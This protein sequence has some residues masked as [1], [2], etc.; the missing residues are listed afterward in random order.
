MSRSKIKKVAVVIPCYNEAASIA[1]V[2]GKLPRKKLQKELCELSVFVVDNN[3]SDNTAQ[4]A[5]K[6][7]ATVIYEPRKGKGYALRAAFANLPG[8]IDYVAML[9]GDDTYSSRELLRM[10]EPLRS[11]FCDVVVGSRLGGHIQASAM[12]PLNRLG[13][14][15][16][17]NAVRVVYR[18]NVTDVLTGYFAWR[19]EALDALHPH[20]KSEGF[21]IEMEM[22]TKMARLKQ[23]L[24]SVPISYHP[25][26]GK[27]NLYPLRDGARILRMF[28]K[29]L[30]WRARNESSSPSRRIVFVSDS[31]Y[32]YMMGGKEKRLHEISK[33]LANMGYD[34]H[35]Y[36]MHWWKSPSKSHIEDGVTFHALCRYYDMYY[37]DR[38]AIKEGI[39]FGLA[40]FKLIGVK[41]DVLDVDHMPFFP[42]LTSWMIC[43]LRGR[44][45][46]GTWHEALSLQD[47]TQYMGQSGIVAALIERISIHLPHT[48]TAASAQT[49]ELLASVHGRVE[50][51]GLVASGIDIDLMKSIKPANIRCDV[52][53]VGRLVKDKNVDVL[54]DAIGVMFK[55]DPQVSCS[56]IG[57]GIE[58]PRLVRQVAK[59]GLQKNI[60]FIESVADAA[61]VYA[62]MKA[63]KVFCSASTREGFGIVSLEALSC[64]TPVV[65]IDTAA[66][67]ARHL[68]QDGQNGSI[69]SLSPAALASSMANW[70]KQVQ[71]PNIADQ[72][73]EYDWNHLAQKQAEVYS[74]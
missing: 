20:L 1:Q 19:K 53:Y 44:K 2:I 16:F 74:L 72:V 21:A 42:I 55:Q 48:I 29:N 59:L 31:V 25:R 17:T 35:I 5:K 23:R 26:L 8:D 57:K 69:V 46:Y 68:I 24:T 45:F 52:L 49:K 61:D 36:T 43:K 58:K 40:C 15:F 37:G 63:A 11:N 27:S 3:S 12:A 7:G 33:R 22:V 64:G 50:R 18:A 56:I 14:W 4:C 39:M 38:R 28:I 6:A 60:T 10:I 30:T 13:N 62:Y 73:T 70:I 71:K 66:N 51:V 41:F 34:I 32:P 9:D 47:W 67:A 65:T 54:I